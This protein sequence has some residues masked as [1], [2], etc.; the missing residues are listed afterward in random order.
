MEKLWLTQP[1][2]EATSPLLCSHSPLPTL[3]LVTPLRGPLQMVSFLPTALKSC[4]P[5]STQKFMNKP[6]NSN[7]TTM[8]SRW[9]LPDWS[10]LNI[11]I[12]NSVEVA[13]FEAASRK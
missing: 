9:T 7:A 13:V 6:T 5:A 10:V 2:Q 3:E 8:Q 11:F 12:T 4:S 1:E